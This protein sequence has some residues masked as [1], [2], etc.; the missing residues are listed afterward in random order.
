MH[1]GRD[2]GNRFTATMLFDQKLGDGRMKRYGVLERSKKVLVI[3]I[4]IIDDRSLEDTLSLSITL[5]RWASRQT[6]RDL[7]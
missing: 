3:P 1:E 5:G 6:D 2:V 7:S 4:I